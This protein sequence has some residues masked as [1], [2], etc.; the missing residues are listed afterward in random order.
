MEEPVE[1]NENVPPDAIDM[2]LKLM[3]N[4]PP[5]S[6]V[7][8]SQPDEIYNP[9]PPIEAQKSAVGTIPP[10][11]VPFVPKPPDTPA[12]NVTLVNV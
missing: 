8:K 9:H 10:N 12:M 6:D 7:S 1:P 5:S 11:H 3:F 2:A 4:S